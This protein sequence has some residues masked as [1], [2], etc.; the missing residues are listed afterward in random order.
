MQ[1]DGGLFYLM[2][3]GSDR[4]AEHRFGIE[5]NMTQLIKRAKSGDAEAFIRLMEDN[6]ESMKP[7][8]I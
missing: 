4:F 5:E 7:S 8:P 2:S 1:P 6:K 3:V